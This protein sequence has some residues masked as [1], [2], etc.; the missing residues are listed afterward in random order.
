MGKLDEIVQLVEQGDVERALALVEQ[1]KQNGSDEE[2]YMLADH[3]FSWGFLEEAEALVHLLL[4]RYP[5]ERELQ[6]F[7]AEIYTEMDKEEEALELLIDIEEDD[8][9]Y[10]RACLLMA[11]LYQMQ[12]L[13]EVSEQKLLKA[14]EKM[15]NEP[16]VQFAL[17]ELYFTSGQYQK[18]LPYYEQVMKQTKTM[19][20][21]V[22]AQRMAEAY[23][24]LG[25]FEQAMVYYEQALNERFDAHTLFQYGFTAYQAEA[26]KT[27]IAKLSELKAL[28]REYVPLYLFLAKSYEQEGDIQQSYE[29]AKEGLTIDEWNKELLV[30]AGKIALKLGKREEA[31]EYIEQALHID[32][33]YL[34]AL[35]IQT[36]LLFHEERYEDVVR[37]IQQALDQGEYDPQFEWELAKAKQKLEMY[38]QALNHYEEAYTFFKD[39]PNFLYDFG[40]F[41]FEEGRREKAKD[42]FEQLLRIDPTNEEIAH[43]MLQFE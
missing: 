19:A 41:L 34:E 26:Y 21:T 12:G 23:S 7:L 40:Y 32:P 20:G 36:S 25:E 5:D 11:D 37:I 4:A 22:L 3:L 2:R 14:Y 9:Y 10:V 1:V 30:Y 15:P 18:S 31:I 27:A 24:L 28:D 42:I 6:L 16:L 29:I 39:D 33:G 17:A 35:F 13:D 43:M 8:P 38:D